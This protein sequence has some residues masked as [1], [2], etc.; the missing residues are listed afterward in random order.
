MDLDAI[1]LE[2]IRKLNSGIRSPKAIADELGVSYNTVRRRIEKLEKEG[3]LKMKGLVDTDQIPNHTLGLVCL[4][5]D[6]RDLANKAREVAQLDGV[7]SVGLVTG[8]FDLVVLV[9]LGEDNDLYNFNIR[10]MGRI[11]GV[12]F[13]ETFVMYNNIDWEVPYVL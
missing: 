9:I 6:T 11:K 12:T 2:I 3:L 10:Q 4:N 7:V 5:F 8:R 13:S 1:N